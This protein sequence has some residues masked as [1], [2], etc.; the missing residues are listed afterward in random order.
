MQ[1][2]DNITCHTY[3]PEITMKH[4]ILIVFTALICFGLISCKKGFTSAIV[5]NPTI[6]EKW[7][8]VN[9]HYYIGSEATGVD[10]IYTGTTTDYWDFRTEGNVY[11]K[12]DASL[13]TLS[14]KLYPDNK[15][16]ISS[17]YFGTITMSNITTLT[18]H[19]AT[20]SAS[21]GLVYLRT[22]NLTR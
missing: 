20:I 10:R 13:D 19:S 3:K 22:I 5:E 4:I 11:I 6:V 17:F 16:T 9:D 1:R 2:Y 21:S 14:Y 15:I 7:N 18:P 8:L 12:E